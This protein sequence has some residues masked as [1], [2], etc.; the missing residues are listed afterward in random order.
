MLGHPYDRR[1]EWLWGLGT[2]TPFIQADEE[3][4]AQVQSG[5]LEMEADHR[6]SKSGYPGPAP[7]A[8]WQV[9]RGHT[10]ISGMEGLSPSP[11][12]PTNP[13]ETKTTGPH[14][15]PPG[16]GHGG[17]AHGLIS[18]RPIFTPEPKCPCARVVSPPLGC[19]RPRTSGGGASPALPMSPDAMCCLAGSQQ[20]PRR[21]LSCCPA[22][23]GLTQP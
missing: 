16:G 13:R 4:E 19:G 18:L 2:G 12:T 21:A 5:D 7:N 14:T 17:Q 22:G 1:Q 11:Q 23:D 3:T 8:T 6:T 10:L 9:L 20:M 15:G